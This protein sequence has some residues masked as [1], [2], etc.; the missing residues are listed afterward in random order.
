MGV[1][2]KQD[3]AVFFVLLPLSRFIVN[4]FET[5][6]IRHLSGYNNDSSLWHNIFT[7]SST[8]HNDSMFMCEKQAPA[9]LQIYSRTIRC[10][11]RKSLKAGWWRWQPWICK[12]D[13]VVVVV[14]VVLRYLFL[15]TKK[16]LV[17]PVPENSDLSQ[18]ERNNFRFSSVVSS[19]TY[20]PFYWH[21]LN[22]P[23]VQ[24]PMPSIE[25]WNSLENPSVFRCVAFV[26]FRRL[27]WAFVWCCS[28]PFFS[29]G[30]E[31][32]RD[33]HNRIFLFD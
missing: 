11:N 29:A 14:V 16:T 8:T 5:Y 18:H 3:I 13:S 21:Y 15:H 1:E 25:P 6:C 27:G 9:E 4:M 19:T 26:V 2:P 24:Y 31:R 7:F 23:E 30:G 33:I 10:C 17:K 22:C 28:C 32:T 20:W 12:A